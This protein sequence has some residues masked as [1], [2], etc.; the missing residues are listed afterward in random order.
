MLKIVDLT[1]DDP[2]GRLFARV[3]RPGLHLVKEA[4]ADLHPEIDRFINARGVK[5]HAEFL[6]KFHGGM[7]K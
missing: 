7:D 4:S 3:I 2:T 5:G 6:Y 1:P